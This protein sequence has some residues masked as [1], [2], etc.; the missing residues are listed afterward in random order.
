MNRWKVAFFGVL[1]LWAL[2]LVVGAYTTVDAAVTT[3][4]AGEG[5]ADCEAHRDWLDAMLRGQVTRTQVKAA[6]PKVTRTVA[7]HSSVLESGD[8]SV[9]YDANGRYA[10]SQLGASTTP[11]YTE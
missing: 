2:T 10:S 7:D 5:R 6:R 8:V 1:G 3:T 4:Y 9:H 11:G